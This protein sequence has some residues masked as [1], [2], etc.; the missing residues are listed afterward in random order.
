MDLQKLRQALTEDCGLSL[1]DTVVLGFSGG[2]DSLTLL[3]LLRE[4]GVPVI[5]AHYDHGLRPE[6]A[7]D[8]VAAGK[9]A[10]ALGARFDTAKGDVATFAQENGQSIEEAARNLRYAYLFTLAEREGAQAVLVAHNADDQAETVLMHLLRGAG[11][12]GLR[13]MQARLLPNSWSA[14]VPLIRPLLST[15]RSQIEAYV[16]EKG[17]SPILDPSNKKTVFFRNKLRL[18]ALPFLEQL[19]PG[20]RA[21][22]NQTAELVAI[23]QALIEA[24]AAEAWRRCLV[25]R[26]QDFV[27]LD[28]AALL[29]E[30]LALQRAVMRRAAGELLPAM[31]DLDY[32]AIERAVHA[33]RPGQPGKQD[34][35]GGLSILVEASSV[36]IAANE[37]KLPADWPQAPEHTVS[38]DLPASMQLGDWRL[39]ADE[40]L[41]E[42]GATAPAVPFQAW[43]DLGLDYGG[44]NGAALTLRRRR[45]GGR[46]QPLGLEQGSQKLSD[47]F[48]NE[49]VPARARAAWPLVTNGDEIVWVPGYRLAHPYRLRPDSK[50][51]L[52]LALVKL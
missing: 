36:W 4:L 48:V 50:R 26:D 52:R 21:R 8:A 31:R 14:S 40:A 3:S 34:W 11:P 51:A 15:W 6:S 32:A 10:A 17:S 5:A 38:I 43:L 49:K 46:F 13:G 45:D 37:A 19:A 29:A 20:F 2:P 30:P 42:P 18:E 12:A 22:L 41:V 33:V 24:L 9:L 25:A 16:D 7:D 28:R 35:L 44:A 1:E 39:T 27:R 47:F 23:D